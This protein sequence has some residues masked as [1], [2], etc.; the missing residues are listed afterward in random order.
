MR[1]RCEANPNCGELNTL[2]TSIDCEHLRNRVLSALEKENKNGELPIKI[3]V[4]QD[5]GRFFT[6]YLHL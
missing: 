2:E 6:D 4:S 3:E 1:N 5:P